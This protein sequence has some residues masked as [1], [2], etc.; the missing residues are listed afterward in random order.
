MW[1][2]SGVCVWRVCVRRAEPKQPLRDMKVLLVWFGWQSLSGLSTRASFEMPH[3]RSGIQL[4]FLW[5]DKQ[6]HGDGNRSGVGVGGDAPVWWE[7]HFVYRNVN[8][9]RG[10]LTA[11][12][13]SSFFKGLKKKKKR[14]KAGFNSWGA[15]ST[16]YFWIF[17]S[18]ADIKYV[19]KVFINIEFCNCLGWDENNHFWCRRMKW[20]TRPPGKFDFVG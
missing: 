14:L 18:K 12:F 7:W 10:N 17:S 2:H 3:L 6:A 11:D 8:F 15:L 13:F 5:P 19:T 4:L 9:I 20:S 16:V 1:D